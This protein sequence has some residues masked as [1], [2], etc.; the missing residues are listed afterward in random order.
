MRK[1]AV[2]FLS[3]L[4]FVGAAEARPSIRYNPRPVPHGIPSH[5]CHSHDH[6][7]YV[8]RNIA[9]AA[10]VVGVIGIIIAVSDD[11]PNTTGNAGYDKYLAE[12]WHAQN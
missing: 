8:A 1:A 7:D 2:I 10:V 5:C 3:V 6:K 4:F 11:G 12:K 9:I